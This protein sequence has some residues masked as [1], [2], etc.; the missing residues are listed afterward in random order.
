[1]RKCSTFRSGHRSI[2][3]CAPTRRAGDPAHILRGDQGGENIANPVYEIAP[4]ASLVIV[5]DEAPQPAM[6]NAP[7]YH[8]VCTASPYMNQAPAGFS[9][10]NRTPSS[11]RWQAAQWP[12]I[13]SRRAGASLRQRAI[14]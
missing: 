8:E 6:A 12:G 5:L 3:G 9:S 14:A 4:N 11:C 13:A 10:G 1:M 2:G 7:E